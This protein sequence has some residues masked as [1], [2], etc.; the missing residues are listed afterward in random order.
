[1][2]TCVNLR[3]AHVIYIDG[4]IIHTCATC[5]C[6]VNPCIC[7]VFMNVTIIEGILPSTL[8]CIL[9]HYECVCYILRA[10]SHEHLYTYVRL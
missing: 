7:T 8:F 1:M 2:F 5:T 10:T 6:M 4:S 3:E 9:L